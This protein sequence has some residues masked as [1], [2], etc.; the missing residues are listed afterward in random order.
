MTGFR[1]GLGAVTDLKKAP[2]MF[3]QSLLPDAEKERLCRD[4]LAEFGV[5][6]V[7]VNADGEMIHSCCLPFGAHKNG[8]ASA[9]ASLNYQRLVYNCLGCGSSGGL[10]WFIA[11]CRGE[12]GEAARAWLDDQTGSG[13]DEQSLSSLLQFFDAVYGPKTR[14]KAAPIPQMSVKV[15]EPWLAIHP[16]MTEDRGIS[17]E[18]LMRFKVG[19]AP[20]MRCKIGETKDTPP[21]PI[22][23]ESERI[24]IPH[25]WKGTLV[26]WQSRRLGKDGTAK[27]LSSPDFPKDTTVFNY[28]AKAP[29]AVVVESPMSVLAAADDVAHFEGTFGAKITDRQCSLLTMHRRLI[30]WLDND[31]AGWKAT[32]RLGEYA[33]AYCDVWVVDSPWDEDAGGLP[34][35]ERARLLDEALTPYALWNPPKTLHCWSCKQPLHEGKC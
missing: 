22:Y 4:L 29:S 30:L 20:T 19:Y 27:Y 7:K 21:K 5:T 32:A 31:E 34:A 11:T 25:F 10:L 13:P 2:G 3:E 8:D 16:Y 26:G 12:S 35:A 33:E 1:K 15:L 6:Q 17:E 9:S 28:D 18:A 23:V 14:N 24:V